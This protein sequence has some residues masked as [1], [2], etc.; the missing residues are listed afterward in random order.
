MFICNKHIKKTIELEI[1][2]YALELFYTI[3]NTVNYHFTVIIF[4]YKK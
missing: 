1:K 4:I 3:Y 2:I